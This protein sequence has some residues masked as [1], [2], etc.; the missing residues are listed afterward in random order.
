MWAEGEEGMK[1]RCRGRGEK[2]GVVWRCLESWRVSRN[3]CRWV[4]AMYVHIVWGSI[5]LV[6]GVIV[7]PCELAGLLRVRVLVRPFCS[8]LHTDTDTQQDTTRHDTTRHDTA[9]RL[10]FDPR[11]GQSSFR[12]ISLDARRQQRIWL[13]GQ[14][15]PSKGES[16][17]VWDGSKRL[18]NEQY[19]GFARG[20]PP[21]YW[22][23]QMRFDFPERTGWGRVLIVWPFMQ[24]TLMIAHRNINTLSHR[25][26]R[27][28]TNFSKATRDRW[29][30]EF[31]YLL[32][33][34][35][36]SEII[37]FNSLAAAVDFC[38]C[39]FF[40]RQHFYSGSVID[41]LRIRD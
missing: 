11:P 30:D 10:R 19:P 7:P 39:L 34:L 26:A 27:E 6:C 38:F 18:Q 20:H 12:W 31:I 32:I 33:D 24:S 41:F 28:Q 15:E 16:L 25:T 37:L 1:C 8:F 17:P 36:V 9:E 40:V 29:M 13:Q 35:F 14:P 3:V 4:L 23:G 21:Y 5:V 22:P 2:E